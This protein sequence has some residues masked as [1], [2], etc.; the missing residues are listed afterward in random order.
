MTKSDRERIIIAGW[1]LLENQ[2][3]SGLTVEAIA[4]ETGIAIAEIQRLYPDTAYIILG[5][6]EPIHE[7]AL[8]QLSDFTNETS[9]ERLFEIIMAHFD[10]ASPYKPGVRRLF[11]EMVWHPCLMALLRP[12]VFKMTKTILLSAG[13]Q[14]SSFL[15]SFKIPVYLGFFLYITWIWL[16]DDTEDQSKTLSALD[17]GLKKWEA[18]GQ[19]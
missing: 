7:R 3:I 4:Q 13:V 11:Q 10:E 1:H 14:T 16:S 15:D 19:F 6:M 18:V 17:Q 8:S 9:S 12:Y 2:G 5:L